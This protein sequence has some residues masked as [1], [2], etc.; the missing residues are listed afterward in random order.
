[1][2]RSDAGRSRGIA[3]G[4]ARRVI[5]GAVPDCANGVP[6]RQLSSHQGP[7]RRSSRSLDRLA[8]RWRT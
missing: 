5:V 1:M 8:Q 3:V 2:T 7:A 6:Y 4:A